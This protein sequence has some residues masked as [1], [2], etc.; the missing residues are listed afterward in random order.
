MED[1]LHKRIISQEEAIGAVSRAMRRTRSG[2]KDPRRPSGTFVF[3]GPSG[4][5]KTDL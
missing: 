1:E 2:L 5:G 4:F 3:L